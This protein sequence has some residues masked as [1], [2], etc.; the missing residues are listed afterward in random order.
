MISSSVVLIISL[1]GLLNLTHYCSDVGECIQQ[2]L[3]TTDKRQN[4]LN[5]CGTS[6]DP[7]EG[8]AKHLMREN[9]TTILQMRIVNSPKFNLP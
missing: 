7:K 2:C 4:G 6:H 3:F 1:Y 9:T 8:R 5:L